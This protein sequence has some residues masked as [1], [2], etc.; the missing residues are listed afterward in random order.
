VLH[1]VAAEMAGGVAAAGVRYSGTMGFVYVFNLVVGFG[2]F[3]LPGVFYEAGLLLGSTFLVVLGFVSYVTTTFV[4]EAMSIGNAMKKLERQNKAIGES[5]RGEEETDELFDRPGGKALGQHPENRELEH[6]SLAH[7]NAENWKTGGGK[8]VSDMFELDEKLELGD[9]AK[10]FLGPKGYRTLVVITAIYLYGDL[11]IYA[12]AAPTTLLALYPGESGKVWVPFLDVEYETD[13]E[14]A[15][16]LWLA[17]FSLVVVPLSCLNFQKTKHLQLFTC[18]YRNVAFIIMIF[19]AFSRFRDHESQ[20]TA[21]SPTSDPSTQPTSNTSD[22]VIED[23]YSPIWDTDDDAVDAPMSNFA[24]LPRLFGAATYSFMCH[25]SIPSIIFPIEDSAR[26]SV[27]RILAADYFFIL[28]FYL[29]LCSSAY[30]AFGTWEDASCNEFPNGPTCG[31]KS[32]YIL[33]FSNS[34]AFIGEL[35][36]MLPVFVC[37]TNFP[38]IAITT[39]NN[40]IPWFNL[41]QN[42]LFFS[43]VRRSQFNRVATNA[44]GGISEGENRDSVELSR[45]GHGEEEE[46]EDGA[47]GFAMQEEDN[48]PKLWHSLLVAVPPVGIAFLVH[49]VSVIVQYTGAY[50]GLALE[51]LFPCVLVVA[52]RRSLAAMQSKLS[53]SAYASPFGGRWWILV[54]IWAIISLCFIVADKVMNISNDLN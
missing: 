42:R 54:F 19:L 15:Y 39:R 41:A 8:D 17:I 53:N 30:L 23:H 10:L 27:N 50:A 2:A 9:M 13:E 35:L 6:L 25:H 4:V 48:R 40:L 20:R 3:T 43:P 33:N 29:L 46:D 37:L 34:G 24:A 52:S 26:R 47:R 44:T 16:N 38:L 18:T 7:K 36:T 22:V 11:A 45:F 49:D 21:S 51:F 32:I 28:G 5:K 14:S 31:V 1:A 12:S